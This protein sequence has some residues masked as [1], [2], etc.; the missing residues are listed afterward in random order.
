MPL[1][2]AEQRTRR[3]AGAHT[4]KRAARR[5]N[6][7]VD[8]DSD[9][10]ARSPVAS[11]GGGAGGSRSD[12]GGID[13]DS[14]DGADDSDS[15]GA[16]DAFAAEASDDAR[17]PAASPGGSRSDSD[18]SNDGPGAALADSASHELSDGDAAAC[19][20]AYGSAVLRHCQRALQLLHDGGLRASTAVA[21]APDARAGPF[22]LSDLILL[23]RAAACSAAVPQLPT[24]ARV[25]QAC[26]R[27]G[28]QA[29]D[30]IVDALRGIRS[31]VNLRKDTERRRRLSQCD[32]PARN[33]AAAAL[34]QLYAMDWSNLLA[35]AECLDPSDPH[36]VQMLADKIR[37]AG[38]VTAEDVQSC[39]E[40]FRLDDNMILKVRDR[41]RFRCPAQI[42]AAWL[43]AYDAARSCRPSGCTRARP[44][45]C[46]MRSPRG[47]AG[48]PAAFARIPCASCARSRSFH[49]HASHVRA[50]PPGM[51]CVQQARPRQNL[52]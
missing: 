12:S 18:N 29:A 37:A 6:S 36:A 7:F 52:L 43:C 46:A 27:A 41:Y 32:N 51:W 1:T 16:D 13:S 39:V 24:A 9:E 48:R 38:H 8:S 44:R 21:A 23:A 26:L 45:A 4:V 5:A 30:V 14:D 17:S 15:D 49:V 47:R 22:P 10:G 19:S 40:D 11:P 50:R 2:A 34:V 35:E 31:A 42:I 3:R 25:R 28:V 33:H 20:A